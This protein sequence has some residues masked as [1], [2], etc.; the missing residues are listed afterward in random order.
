MR[1]RAC[2]ATVLATAS[3]AFAAS[4]EIPQG[5]SITVPS[6][7]VAL[8]C[9]NVAVRGTWNLG[10]TQVGPT[11]SVTIDAGGTLNAGSATLNVGGNWF[12]SGAFVRGTSNVVFADGCS[13]G[14]IV[15][16]G[17]T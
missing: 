5:A 6:G 11:N 17:A 4:L 15:I 12:N 1:A 2:L 7:T 8:A 16:G 10:A 9:A 13:T 14:P 3:Q